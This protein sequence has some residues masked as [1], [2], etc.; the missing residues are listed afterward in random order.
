MKSS[1]ERKDFP[2]R[3]WLR[4]T[5]LGALG[6]TLLAGAFGAGVWRGHHHRWGWHAMNDADIARVKERAVAHLG[7]RLDLDDGQKAKLGVLADRLR[8]QRNALVPAGSPA[9]RAEFAALFAGSTFDRT[10]AQALVTAKT[11]AIG[12]K[13]PDVIAALGDFYDSLSPAQQEKVRGYMNRGRHG[14]R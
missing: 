10:Q 2:M 5:L 11:A 3:T 8:E 9:P 13:A 7:R 1:L 12:S 4:R 6:A 14:R